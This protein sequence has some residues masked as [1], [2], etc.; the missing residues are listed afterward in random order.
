MAPPRRDFCHGPKD[1]VPVCHVGVRDV[2]TFRSDDFLI[3]EEDIH[4]EG[5]G[6]PVDPA[7]SLCLLFKGGAEIEQLFRCEKSADHAGT[8][9][10]GILVGVAVGSRL[11]EGGDLQ[12]TV[13]FFIFDTVH[14]E[15]EHRLPV[16]HIGAEREE[17]GVP[18]A[19]DPDG[20]LV[21]RKTDGCPGL[22][23]LEGDFPEKTFIFYEKVFR[24]LFGAGLDQLEAA[25]CQKIGDL[26]ADLSVVNGVLEIVGEAGLSDIGAEHRGYGKFLT[27][28][29]FLFVDA[30][31]CEYR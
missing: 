30:V 7:D 23:D 6:T 21:E 14:G 25:V 1:K 3:V 2:E 8:V 4:V 16:T 17:G 15:I 22:M 12:E 29:S 24:K 31:L 5:A 20:D 19:V 9:E 11:Y 18:A 27:E 26:V 10:E 13:L 28:H